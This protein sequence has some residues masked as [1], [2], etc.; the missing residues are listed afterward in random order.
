MTATI[1]DN[2]FSVAFDQAASSQFEGDVP[3]TVDVDVVLETN[4][5]T[6]TSAASVEVVVVRRDCDTRR[7]TTRSV[8][9]RGDLSARIG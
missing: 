1:T 6:L 2:D 9:D 4:G 7:P 5:R 3:T 8:A